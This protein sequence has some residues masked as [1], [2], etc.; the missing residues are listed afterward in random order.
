MERKILGLSL[1]DKMNHSKI[2][3]QTKFKDVVRHILKLKWSWAGHIGRMSDNRWTKKCTRWAPSG[4]RRRGRPRL[5]WTD[6]LVRYKSNW[7]SLT[8]DRDE[9]KELAEG[10]VL[11]WT[12]MASR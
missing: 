12:D 2:R 3:E 8:D 6:D 9:W 11:Q 4:K 5:R 7:P 1:L 10:Y